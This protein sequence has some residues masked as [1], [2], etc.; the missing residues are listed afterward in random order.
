MQGLIEWLLLCHA[1]GLVTE[2][3]IGL[4]LTKIGSLEFIEELLAEEAE[5]AESPGASDL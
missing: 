4:D 5:K 3:E 2:K 1:A